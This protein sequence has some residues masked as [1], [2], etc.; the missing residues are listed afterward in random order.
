MTLWDSFARLDLG[1]M[2]KAVEKTPSFQGTDLNLYPEWLSSPRTIG[3]QKRSGIEHWQTLGVGRSCLSDIGFFF[4][5][6][7][8]LPDCPDYWL[9]KHQLIRCSNYI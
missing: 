7:R 5:N 3:T 2:G 1:W 8:V 9:T 4:L 6:K